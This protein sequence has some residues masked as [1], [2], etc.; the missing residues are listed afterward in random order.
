MSKAEIFETGLINDD[1]KQN[2]LIKSLKP[3][4]EPN[5]TTFVYE[6]KNME[7]ARASI[8]FQKLPQSVK[9]LKLGY[10]SKLVPL[11]QVY[12]F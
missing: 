9:R 6:A 12:L 4:L 7:A 3:K 11:K 10:C 1:E 5:H 2:E 8:Q